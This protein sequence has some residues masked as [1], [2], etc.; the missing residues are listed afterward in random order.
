[1]RSITKRFPGT[2]ALRD[3]G[4]DLREGEILALVG[5]NGAGK[6][7]L[8]KIL[9][10][11][12]P[13]A[14]YEGEIL[15]RG[16]PVAF[17]G[18]G[19]SERAG[20]EMIYQE[21]SMHLDLTIAEN[22]F[23]GR[24]PK[25]RFGLVD[26]EGMHGAARDALAMVGLDDSPTEI[27]RNL[28]V[29][30]QQLVAIARALSRN[31]KILVLDEPT[32]ALTEQETARLLKLVAGLRDGGL[33]C[34]YISHKLDEV[35]AVADRITILRD[36]Q[37]VATLECDEAN[38]D[39][40]I[41]D[42]VGRKIE[43]LFPKHIAEPGSEVFRAEHFTVPHP[44]TRHKNIIDDV[45]FHVCR[46]EILGIAG[47]VGSGRSEL[48]NA[49]F[50]ALAHDGAGTVHVEGQPVQ[51]DTPL[52]AIRSGIGLLTEDRRKNGYIGMLDVCTNI[53]L[54]SLDRISSAS[55]IDNGKERAFAR[56]YS[57]ELDIRVAGLDA[58]MYSLSGG[59]QQK[60]ILARW[61]MRN[62]KVL[63]LDEP[64]RGID[65]GAKVKIYE[66]MNECV[67]QGVGIVMIS[68]EL[69]ELMAMCDRFIVLANG[70]IADEFPRQDVSAERIM[71]ACTEGGTRNAECGRRS[72]ERG[73]RSA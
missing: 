2:V 9:S 62:L 36:G 23:L 29:S 20:I 55:L 30:R 66:I 12:Y 60:V 43:Q 7:T 5:E 24:L 21:I 33:S 47:L 67:R 3:V 4:L 40:V 61:L 42:M 69:P 54:A 8:M 51:I 31:P 28:S 56:R 15:V 39:R 37:S 26:L 68:S 17:D 41:E 14:S 13:R 64:T 44:Y 1:M 18:P 11:A 16:E 59:N 27:V 19:D 48:V 73:M 52:D 63:I 45:G 34:I 53:T 10:G 38:R 72:A 71:H 25:D 6:S 70:R 65:I 46:G 22:I 57:E 50:G 32:S 49:V 58:E 35:F